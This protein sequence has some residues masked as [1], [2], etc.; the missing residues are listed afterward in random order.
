MGYVNKGKPMLSFCYSRLGILFC[1][2]LIVTLSSSASQSNNLIISTEEQTAQD[3]A[4]VPCK[5]SERPKAVKSLFSKMG[6]QTEDVLTEK[7]DGVENI[8]VRKQGKAQGIIVVGAHYDKTQDGCGAIDNWTGIVA[9]THIY[10][11]LK[12]ADFQKT[13]IFVA[14]GK[15]EQGLFGSR[16]MARAIKKD[17]VG[18]YCAMVNIDSLGMAAPQVSENLSSKTLV[19]RVAEL[20]QRMKMP[21]N[22]VSIP[23]AGADS[24]PFI[25]KK[26]PAV[27]ISALGNGWGEVLHTRS[28]QVAKVN[29]TSVYLGYR[30]ALALIAELDNLACEASREE[31]KAK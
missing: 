30:L 5:D 6:A 24:I 26:I 17:E 1:L 12:D 14:F 18:Q 28:D 25:E 10:R 23:R 7:R 31:P 29:S 2:P 19:N 21:F 11:S 27:T 13:L 16:A 22:K 15:E 8:I 4:Q 20:A 9:L 3:T